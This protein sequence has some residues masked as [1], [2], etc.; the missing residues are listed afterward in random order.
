MIIREGKKG[1]WSLS[2]QIKALVLCDSAVSK[3]GSK[4]CQREKNGIIKIGSAACEKADVTI[5]TKD[6]FYKLLCTARVFRQN[7]T[8][9]K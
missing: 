1:L 4:C 9:K 8:E 2:Q 3:S 7:R 6:N 5:V